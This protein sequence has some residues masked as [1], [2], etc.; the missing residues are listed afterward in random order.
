MRSPWAR[1]LF[2]AG[3]V[4]GCD[5][6]QP[7]LLLDAVA[8]AQAYRD[9]D[10][11]LTLVGSNFIPA[12][13]LDPGSGQ[14]TAMPDGF[15]ARVGMG[16]SLW[17]ELTGIERLSNQLM[18]AWL[19]KESALPLPVGS[20]NVELTDPRGSKALLLNAFQEL[21]HD[22]TAPSLSFTTPSP[23]T[24][25]GAG[26]TL[27]A[28]FHAR[29]APSE[30]LTILRWEYRENGV[31]SRQGDCALPS[32]VAA[33]ADCSFEV[34]I[35]ADLPPATIIEIVAYASDTAGD[36]AQPASLSR[37]FALKA[38]PS[39]T[40][41]SPTSGSTAGGTDIVIKGSGF[42]PGSQAWLDNQLIIP[43]GGTVVDDQTISGYAPARQ[44]AGLVKLTVHSPVG[45]ISKNPA[46]VYQTPPDA[47]VTDARTSVVLP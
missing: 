5:D 8:P 28:A 10:V 35:G 36:A 30:A 21:G 44:P 40:L 43:N 26:T 1:L 27:S 24:P 18:T 32:D 13:V 46:F 31:P 23:D 7:Q 37:S 19:T 25:F 29:V 15:H 16:P 41:V 17:S 6:S 11:Q 39:I 34:T 45:E 22:L 9:R 14:R 4:A 2:Y 38:P 42:L 3:L 20:L 12:T 47:G 33:E